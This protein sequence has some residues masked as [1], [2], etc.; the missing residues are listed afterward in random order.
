MNLR[1]SDEK[2]RMINR[3]LKG[4]GISNGR[5][6][7]VF[8]KVPREEFVPEEFKYSA[9][10]DTALPIG[11]GQTISQ[12]YIVARMLQMLDVEKEN[13][14]LEIGTGSGYQTALLAE[15]ALTVVTIERIRSL[16]SIAEDRLT[17]L[18]YHNIV[19]ILGD[20]SI[21]Y[22]KMAPYDRIIV[23]AASP[24]IPSSLFN[25]LKEGGRM[26]IPIG[27]SFTQVLT[28]VEKRKGKQVISYGEGCV[29]VPLIG[30]EGF[31]NGA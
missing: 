16:L 28:L 9:Y 26:V 12:P 3:D 20:G 2:I 19:F 31:K 8:M 17:K 13:N 24:D 10:A 4:R 7:Q 22:T 1:Y 25:Q 27:G 14:V 30:K 21:G 11:N 18:G 23:S 29:F 6:L 5:L 15:L